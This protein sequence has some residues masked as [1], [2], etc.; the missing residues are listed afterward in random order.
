MNPQ[1]RY[2]ALLDPNASSFTFQTFDDGQ[3]RRW[4]AAVFEGLL[5]LNKRLNGSAQLAS[6]GDAYDQGSGVWVTV[7]ETDGTGRKAENIVRVR[8]VW[9]EFDG[10]KD[11]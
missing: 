6:I 9:C 2:F 8:A 10:A 11:G 1:Q 3:N 4:L 5:A 7:N